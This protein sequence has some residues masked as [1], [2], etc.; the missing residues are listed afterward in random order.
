LR[1]FVRQVTGYVGASALAFA[2][3]FLLLT[4]LV[5]RCG[6]PYL[7]AAAVSFMSGTVFVY[8]VS[9]RHL[10]EH[11]RVE[12]RRHEFAI[13]AGIGLVGL[14]L[15]LT[16]MYVL[17]DGFGLYYLWAKVC[18]AGCTLCANFLLRRWTLF[19]AQHAPDHRSGGAGAKP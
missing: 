7:L 14:V 4:L 16:V 13:F 8:W 2:L 19:T 9:V 6:V 3:D 17:V 10:F 1:P 5:S 18:A 11:R 12:N 15:N